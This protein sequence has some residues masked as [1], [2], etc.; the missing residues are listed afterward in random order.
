M[1][2][3]LNTGLAHLAICPTIKFP[4]SS[5]HKSLSIKYFE[6]QIRIMADAI[7]SIAVQRL[8]TLVEKQI[9]TK[10]N[11]VRGVKNEVS[12]LSSEL[13]A[14]RNVLDDAERRRYKEKNIQYWLKKLEDTSYDIDNVLDEWNFAILKLEIQGSKDFVPRPKVRSYLNFSKVATR[15]D[16]AKKIKGLK[17]RLD[18]IVNEKDRYDFIVGQPP[19]DHRE[20]DRVR[21]TSL[22]D[23]SEIHGRQV[24]KDVLVSKLMIEG[25]VGEKELINPSV[26]SIVGT[27]GIGKTTLA[28]LLYNDD[29]VKNNFNERIWICVSDVFDEVRIAKGIVEIV[30]GS[31]PN[32]NE[33]ESL[34]KCL[35]DSI[36]GKKF[37]LVMDDVWTEDYTKWEPLKK[38]LKLGGPGSKF[39]VTTRSERVARMMGSTE[40]YHLGQ[41][42]DKDCWALMRRVAFSGRSCEERSCEELLDIGKNIAY[43]CKG[44]PL[45]AKVLGSMLLFKD[46]VEEWRNVLDSEIWQLE[47]AEVDLFPHLL[48]S[49]NELAPTIKH[50]FSY[51]AVFPKDTEIDVEKLIRMWMAQGYLVSSSSGR[52]DDLELRGKEYFNNLRMRCFFLDYN[53]RTCKMHDIVH[54]FAQFLR[55]TKLEAAKEKG[56]VYRS[57]ICQKELLLLDLCDCNACLRVLSLCECELQE[58][59]TYIENLIHLR[60]LDLTDNMLMVQVPQSICK[61]YNLETLYLG[62]CGLKEIPAEIGNLIRLRH[63]DLYLNAELQE[64]PETIC[65]LHELRTLNLTHC[66]SLGQLPEGIHRLINLRHLPNEH[67]HCLH[68]IPQGLEQLTGL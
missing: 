61:L 35:T 58:I 45:A 59:P 60:Y 20:S 39:L 25:V 30:R 28:Q 24:E 37:L 53:G 26:I 36:S 46:T 47:E 62:R 14:I 7:V 13:N 50:C 2:F 43:K 54:D 66:V 5:R 12:Y 44:L 18:R 11:L 51:C 34:L 32:L 21:S 10:I 6:K 52:E 33:L 38:S 8:E 3:D 17:E 29:T 19:V 15:H 23:V 40:M 64:L 31:C 68:Q 56:S 41:L 63:L 1:G 57:L 55:K 4:I 48:L 27:G 22:L 67:T 65:N 16:I 49:Y 42:S 9:G